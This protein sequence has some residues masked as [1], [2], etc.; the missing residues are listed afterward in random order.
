MNIRIVADGN[1]QGTKVLG[2]DDKPI[3]H[4]RSAVFRHYAGEMPTVE[5][6]LFSAEIDVS[7]RAAFVVAAPG[8]KFSQE[9]SKI[10]FADGSEWV[11]P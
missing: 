5:L 3:E 2:E 7:G 1:F 8:S 10:T 4:V 11:A 9:V 6:E